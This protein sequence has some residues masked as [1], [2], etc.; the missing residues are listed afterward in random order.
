[1]IMRRIARIVVAIALL[2]LPCSPAYA[3]SG[4][5]LE[6]VTID[7]PA[8][9]TYPAD[10]LSENDF[11]A[12]EQRAQEARNSGV[13]LAVRIVDVSQTAEDIP[14]AIRRYGS[15]DYTLPISAERQAQFLSAWVETE[16][17]ETSADADDGFLLLVLVPE[18]RTQTQAFWRIGPN[19]LPLNS[20]TE[21]NIA[22]TQAVM[23]EQF[24]A[25][26]MPNGVY[27]GISLF[28]YYNQFGTPERLLRSKMQDALHTATIPLGIGAALAGLAIPVVAWAISRRSASE[29]AIDAEITPWQ[30]AALQQGR[31]TGAITAAMLLDAV[32]AGAATPTREGGLLLHDADFNSAI[33]LLKPFADDDGLVPASAMLEV[34]AITAPVRQRIEDNLA[35][36]GAYNARALPERTTLLIWMGIAAFIA[37]LTVVP[38]V[39]AMSRVGVLGIAIAAIGVLFGWW[40]L[41]RRRYTTPAGRRL[42]EQWRA[43]ASADDLSRLY[44]VTAQIYLLGAPGGPNASA[45]THLMRR[46]RGLG[47]H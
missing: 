17:V 27:M 33:A 13:P 3:R 20:L 35:E 25:G 18:D 31:A 9:E 14:F 37:V 2:V 47:A 29:E 16:P 45:Q 42:F 26:N 19:A 7:A 30:A 24:A 34:D 32:H 39:Q 22:E 12:V 8:L 46:L 40:W 10:L 21:A 28:S 1:M 38:T 11:D 6:P 4:D 23:Q 44:L 36:I 41:S 15:T 5:T 43:S